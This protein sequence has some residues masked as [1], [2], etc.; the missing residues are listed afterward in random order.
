MG[1]NNDRENNSSGKNQDYIDN[2]SIDFFKPSNASDYLDKS[3]SSGLNV[4]K[5]MRYLAL[6][7]LCAIVAFCAFACHEIMHWGEERDKRRDEALELQR[8]QFREDMQE[9]FGLRES[10]YTIVEEYYRQESINTYLIFSCGGK[11]Y[12]Y[13]DGNTDYK[14]EEFLEEA[15]AYILKQVIEEHPWIADMNPEVLNIRTRCASYNCVDRNMLPMGVHG[16]TVEWCLSTPPRTI[17]NRKGRF[18][19]FHISCELQICATEMPDSSTLLT[20]LN[21]AVPAIEELTLRCCQIDPETQ[22]KVFGEVKSIKY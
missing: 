2:Q 20:R 17:E 3:S 13:F 7:V 5:T 18:D 19:N 22:E 21:D 11:E 15:G 4:K 12:G 6:I 16:E 9:V 8:K 1:T 14:S 10:D